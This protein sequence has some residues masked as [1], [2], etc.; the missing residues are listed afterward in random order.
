MA[1]HIFLIEK[2]KDLETCLSKSLWIVHS[3][4]KATYSPIQTQRWA[5]KARSTWSDR[6]HQ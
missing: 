3:F 1:N 6:V 2:L 4:A 5:I